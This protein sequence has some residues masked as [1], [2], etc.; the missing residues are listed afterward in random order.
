[1]K[2]RIFILAAALFV[3]STFIP[4]KA[5]AWSIFP[6]LVP[7]KPVVPVI[8]VIPVI[9]IIPIFPTQPVKSTTLP[10]DSGIVFL[11]I[12][13]ITMGIITVKKSSSVLKAEFV[14]A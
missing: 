3:L 1:M 13:G 12:A 7:V 2:S 9:P 14:K 11:V 5:K 4:G 6:P 8:P 10:I